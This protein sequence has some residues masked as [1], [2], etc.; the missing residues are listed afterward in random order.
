MTYTCDVTHYIKFN[1]LCSRV[2]ASCCT[3]KCSLV[4]FIMA[5]LTVISN[6]HRFCQTSYTFH[7]NQ[8]DMFSS[9]AGGLLYL[10][11]MVQV[12]ILSSIPP[13]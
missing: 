11:G 13:C 4:N 7:R 5:L 3:Y 8:F 9:R 12:F 6:V 10:F 2:F 1:E